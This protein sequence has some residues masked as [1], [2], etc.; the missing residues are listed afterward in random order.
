MKKTLT[1]LIFLLAF[2]ITGCESSSGSATSSNNSSTNSSA[3]NLSSNDSKLVGTWNGIYTY[4]HLSSSN[5]YYFNKTTDSVTYTFSG[6]HEYT[7]KSHEFETLCDSETYVT[8]PQ[9]YDT[10]YIEAWYNISGEWK[11]SGDTLYMSIIATGTKK[12]RRTTLNDTEYTIRQAGN[13]TVKYVI[14][15]SMLAFPRDS[16]FL[17][18]Q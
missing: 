11:A 3:S 2:G 16:L 6:N 7:A 5:S 14:S 10:A 9:C 8:T 1:A 17:S 18:K 13:D 4:T 12:E 15:S